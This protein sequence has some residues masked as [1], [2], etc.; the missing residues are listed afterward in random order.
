METLLLSG[1]TSIGPNGVALGRPKISVKKVADLC[2]S[3]HQT[4]V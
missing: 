2:L 3:R 4:I 1:T